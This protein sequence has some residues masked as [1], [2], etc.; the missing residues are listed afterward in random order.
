MTVIL[1]NYVIAD[2]GSFEIRRPVNLAISAKEAQRRVRSWLCLDVAMMLTG[3]EPILIV[4]EA[5]RWQVPVIF[6]A[7][8]VGHVG[9]VGNVEVDAQT[10]LINK[11]PENVEIMLR[12]AE[13]LSKTL[14]PFKPL[15]LPPEYWAKHVQP[16]HQPGRPT[17]DP[18][19]LIH[20]ITNQ[21]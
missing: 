8:H 12:A 13:K 14:P 3:G 15:E 9:I 7:P 18:R 4:G 17:G 6:T 16:T 1:E 19:D 10:G 11:D 2:V 5:T 21:A 20:P